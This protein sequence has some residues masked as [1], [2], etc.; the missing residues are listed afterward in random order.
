MDFLDIAINIKILTNNCDV[1]L[2]YRRLNQ[3]ALRITKIYLLPVMLRAF[4]FSR[5]LAIILHVPT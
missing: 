3:K 4:D 2:C 5:N 1:F